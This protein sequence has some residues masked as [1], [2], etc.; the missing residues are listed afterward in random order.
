MK[1]QL[2]TNTIANELTGASVFFQP[3]A[4]LPPS[5]PTE[6]S[7][8]VPSHHSPPQPVV[9]SDTRNDSKLTDQQPTQQPEQPTIAQ[10]TA[11]ATK[12]D[13]MTPRYH[14]TMT[15]RPDDGNQ[16]LATSTLLPLS[17]PV[18]N[19]VTEPR[20]PHTTVSPT[21]IER[22][23]K[24]VK[25]LGKEVATHRFT[26]EEKRALAEVVFAYARR[27]CKTSE[28]ELTR[29]AVNWLLLDYQEQGEQSVLAQVVRALK[30]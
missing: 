15:P 28:N 6:S 30:E 4:S 10:R 3:P 26:P 18:S 22:V 12:N 13:T 23:R 7:L 5:A 1:K 2:P 20:H 27:G 19:H 25:Q 21:R 17:V 29:I 11:V 14:D 9:A 24:A 8:P 16:E